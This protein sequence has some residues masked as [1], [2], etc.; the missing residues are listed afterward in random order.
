MFRGKH[1]RGHSVGYV[2][3]ELRACM[4]R[5]LVEDTG[6]VSLGKYKFSSYAYLMTAKCV[7]T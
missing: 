7:R 2:A 1:A 5:E 4:K 6:R 3:S